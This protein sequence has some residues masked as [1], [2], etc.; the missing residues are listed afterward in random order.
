MDTYW[1]D[2]IN[3]TLFNPILLDEILPEKNM[4]YSQKVNSLVRLSI[5]L[6]LILCIVDYRFLFL[7]IIFMILTYILYLYRKK[8]NNN[9]T[10]NTTNNTSNNINNYYENFKNL[11][12]SQENLPSINN[13]FMNAMPFDSRT[14]NAAPYVNTKQLK[15]DIETNFNYYLMKDSGD[16]FN[17]MN[18]RR[19]F[20][21]MA[22]TSN[23]NKQNEFAL[24][25]YGNNQSCK[26]NTYKCITNK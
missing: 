1:F 22:N 10:N 5:Y 4:T 9:T 18:S 13:P 24:W 17:T 26:E 3:E 8:Y 6:G 14:K 20:Y 7:P 2:N 21:T 25:L 23:F 11:N 12:N 15:N 16:I 19:Q